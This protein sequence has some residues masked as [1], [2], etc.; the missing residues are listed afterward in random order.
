MHFKNETLGCLFNQL[1]NHEN[2]VVPTVETSDIVKQEQDM[3]IS[4]EI[5]SKQVFLFHAL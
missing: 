5:P 3:D 2:H 4:I 1:V